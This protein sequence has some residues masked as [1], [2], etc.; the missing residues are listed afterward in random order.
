M[1]LDSIMTRHVVTV[2]M[3]DELH[4]I[5][6][7]FEKYRFHHVLVVD[8]CRVVG[9]ISD[10]DLLKNVSPFVGK[11][12]ERT[13]DVQSL[14]R[15]AHQIMTRSLISGAP[16]TPIGDAA[17]LMLNNRISCLPVINNDGACVGIVTMR[18]LLRWSLSQMAN[19]AC[20]I[21]LHRQSM[22]QSKAA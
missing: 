8:Q 9:V 4:I 19:Q 2:R 21:E 1:T 3:D 22:N 10:R 5:R 7:M 6:D 11:L 17:L 20:V 16:N 15:K 18:D 14:H 12:A 13:L